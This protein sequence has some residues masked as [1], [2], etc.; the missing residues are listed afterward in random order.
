MIGQGARE[1][2]DVRR[3]LMPLHDPVLSASK[4]LV[5]AHA[6]S[7]S[8]HTYTKRAVHSTQLHGALTGI[9]VYLFLHFAY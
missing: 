9:I 8:K 5:H 3:A 7:T 1:V 2:G 4:L 6:T